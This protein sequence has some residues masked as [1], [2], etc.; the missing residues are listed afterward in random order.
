MMQRVAKNCNT[1][2]HT[3]TPCNTLQRPA[4]H[5]NTLL[6]H[7]MKDH[8]DVTRCHTLQQTE[9]L[10]HTA[11]HCSTLHNRVRKR[12]VS[13]KGKTPCPK[14][15]K[16]KSPDKKPYSNTKRAPKEP[17]QKNPKEPYILPKEPYIPS[18]EPHI[19]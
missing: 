7:Q 6:C 9:T 1:L 19:L 11:A 3:A 16:Q 10:Q 14:P 17:L 12:G 2:Q 4:T 8:H 5:C 15:I 18:K 13:F